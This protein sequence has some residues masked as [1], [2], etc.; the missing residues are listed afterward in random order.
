[1]L[2]E[3]AADFFRIL[4]S[5]GPKRAALLQSELKTVTLKG[6]ETD[7]KREFVIFGVISMSETFKPGAARAL[8]LSTTTFVVCLVCALALPRNE[9][10]FSPN[11]Q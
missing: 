1:M 10:R 2:C 9:K 4:M 5:Q 3:A 11:L 7:I 6:E 8:S